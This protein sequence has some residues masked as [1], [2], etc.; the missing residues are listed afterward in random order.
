MFTSKMLRKSTAQSSRPRFRKI[1]HSEPH[2]QLISGHWAVYTAKPPSGSLT[3]TREL[4]STDYNV[5]WKQILLSPFQKP[6]TYFHSMMGR[7]S[8]DAFL[9]HIQI[10]KTVFVDQT[11]SPRMCSI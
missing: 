2:H 3:D 10:S 5:N 7:K 1:Y 9:M 4:K 11:V 6:R 8:F